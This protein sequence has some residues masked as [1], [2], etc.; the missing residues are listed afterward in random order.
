[1]SILK[2]KMMRSRTSQVQQWL[3]FG[4]KLICIS[5]TKVTEKLFLFSHPIKIYKLQEY[6]PNNYFH[7]HPKSL[8]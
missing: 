6:V 5:F 8:M 4:A 7:V 2:E 1:M 3:L